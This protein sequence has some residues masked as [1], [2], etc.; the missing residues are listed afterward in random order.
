MRPKKSTKVIAPRT[1]L[2]DARRSVTMAE[3]ARLC[4]TTKMTVSR[5][6]AGR[7]GV[8]EALREKVLKQATRLK[9]EVNQQASSFSSNRVNFIGLVTPFE[10]LLG[11]RYFQRVVEGLNRGLGNHPHDLVLFDM[12][13]PNFESGD[14]LERVWRQRKV[15]GFVILAPHTTDQFIRPLAESGVPLV[16]VGEVDPGHGVASITADDEQ[17]VRMAIEHLAGYGHK[18]IAY[19]GGPEMLSSAQRRLASYRE[20]MENVGLEVK[21][22][23]VMP[24]NY[25]M[26]SGREAGA[27]LFR[28]KRRPTA[29]FAANDDMALGVMQA[30][31]AEGLRVPEDVSVVG[32][33][34]LAEAAEYWPALT[35]VHQPIRR[36]GLVASNLLLAQIVSDFQAPQPP[37]LDCNLVVRDSTAPLE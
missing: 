27:K 18:L 20:T 4:G 17:G 35:T 2:K 13:S 25:T 7:P 3:I 21:E 1:K 5:V 30:A 23:M 28:A 15:D 36:I 6:F 37:P 29:V 33:D 10:G 8:S 19:V 31:M 16:V 32:F 26:R 9:Y 22:S 12:L 14:K 24:G 11:S 34:D